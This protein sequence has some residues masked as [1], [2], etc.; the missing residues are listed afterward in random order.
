MPLNRQLWVAIVVVIAVAFVSSFLISFQIARG[1]FS[2]ELAVKNV[3]NAN[4]LALALSGVDKDPVLVELMISAQFD[5]GYYK[6]LSLVDTDGDTIIERSREVN[7]FENVP[8]WFIGLA[9]LR[10]EPGVAQV[11]AGW[12]QYGTLSVESRLGFAYQALWDNAVEL[13]ISFLLI[14]VLLGGLGSLV[15][16]WLISPLSLVVKQAEGIGDRRFSTLEVPKTEEFGRLVSAMNRLSARVKE[17]IDH[18]RDRLEILHERLLCDP[19]TGM[20]NLE[21]F[22]DVLFA[23]LGDDD[24]RQHALFSVRLLNLAEIERIAG[25]KEADDTVLSVRD[26]IR[27]VVNEN[28]ALYSDSQVARLNDHDFAIILADS[29]DADEFAERLL[30][31]LA[32]IARRDVNTEAALFAVAGAV[33]ASGDTRSGLMRRLDDALARAEHVGG[34]RLEWAAWENKGAWLNTRSDWR[35]VFEEAIHHRRISAEYFPVRRLDG[36]LIHR[37]GMM[38]L[39]MDDQRWTAGQFLPWARRLGVLPHLDILMLEIALGRRKE[40]GDESPVAFNLS[41]ECLLDEVSRS[42]LVALL[43]QHADCG[44]RVS[45]EVDERSTVAHPHAFKELLDAAIPAGFQ[46]G[47]D[48]AGIRLGGVEDLQSLGLAYIKLER[49]LFNELENNASNRE[50]LGGVTSLAHALGIMVI[51]DGIQDVAE[52]QY[53]EVCGVD[54]VSGPGAPD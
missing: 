14:A 48:K 2:E 1:Y 22:N 53:L 51:A 4:M 38:R 27:Q 3:D 33:F 17:I 47:L 50:Y 18:Q 28:P 21:H 41:I 52:M 7:A 32:E 46:V 6:R 54:G 20:A 24:N 16:R 9:D 5:T 30:R 31:G 11:Q 34:K 12:R 10:I 42:Q 25:T 35:V 19:H 43:R 26:T 37:E 23:L 29:V 49:S 15:L 40:S 44:A 8:G 45:L 36:E 39:M 13:F